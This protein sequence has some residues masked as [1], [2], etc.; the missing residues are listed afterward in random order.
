MVTRNFKDKSHPLASSCAGDIVVTLPAGQL[1]VPSQSQGR[2]GVTRGNSRKQYIWNRKPF[3]P[4]QLLNICSKIFGPMEADVKKDQFKKCV[5]QPLL[6]SLPNRDVSGESKRGTCPPI[7][8]LADCALK[9][10]GKSREGLE[11]AVTGLYCRVMWNSE[12]NR[13]E[14]LGNNFISKIVLGWR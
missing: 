13:R 6:S 11:R 12:K 1:P 10:P 2:G 7:Q 4:R 3:A 9:K 8:F 14:E 5:L